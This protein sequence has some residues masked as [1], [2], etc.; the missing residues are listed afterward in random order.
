[1][2]HHAPPVA[3]A[4]GAALEEEY[5]L[6][7]AEAVLAGTLALMTG[8]AQASCTGQ[9]AAMA[10]KITANLQTLARRRG[11]SP[12]FTAM[13]RNLQERWAQLYA[14]LDAPSPQGAERASLQPAQ[15]SRHALRMA[16]PKVLQ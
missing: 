10:H 12:A 6:S 7:G 4:A 15:P 16:A 1:M 3:P 11:G 8:H 2:N 5:D 13:L 9:R 14:A